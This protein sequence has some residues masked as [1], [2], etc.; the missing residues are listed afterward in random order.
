ML[1]ICVA[2]QNLSR[3]SVAESRQWPGQLWLCQSQLIFN[4]VNNCQRERS[5]GPVGGS[6]SSETVKESETG[7]MSST[8]RSSGF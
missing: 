3:C 4:C 6:S 7:F 2:G 5:K 8:K 1:L